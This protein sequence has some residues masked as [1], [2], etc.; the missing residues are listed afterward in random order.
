MCKVLSARRR[1]GVPTKIICDT[2][3]LLF[4]ANEPDRLT[5]KARQVLDNNMNRGTLACSDMTLWE[6]AL[7]HERGRILLPPDV[8]IVRYMNAI[9]NAL[10]L[11]VLSITP[12]IAAISCSELFD[13]HDPA[14]RLI[15]ATAIIHQA[16]LIT[17]DRKLSALPQLRVLW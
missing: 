11:D 2:H 12:E 4:W 17:A 3:V 9:I 6:M 13:H 7:L 1:N 15:A 16:P 5:A 10:K 8:A 14:D